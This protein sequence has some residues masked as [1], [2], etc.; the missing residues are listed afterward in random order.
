M[1]SVLYSI[2]EYRNG[3][4]ARHE[5]PHPLPFS[6]PPILQPMTVRCELIKGQSPGGLARSYVT[7]REVGTRQQ[8]CMLY[9]QNISR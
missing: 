5:A 4:R 2:R 7:S 9:V 1:I 8:A 6:P 3:N